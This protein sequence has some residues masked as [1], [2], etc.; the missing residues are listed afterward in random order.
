MVTLYADC[1]YQ[2][3][4]RS[5]GVGRYNW[6]QLGLPNDA[7]SSLRVSPG[8]V[9]VLYNDADFRG[10]ATTITEN[11]SCLTDRDANDQTSSIE[12]RRVPARKKE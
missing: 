11:V 2:G 7:L 5:I 8:M 12:V 1:D 4:G 3:V 6:N 10:R 9:V